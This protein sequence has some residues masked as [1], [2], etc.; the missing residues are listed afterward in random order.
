MI[1]LGNADPFH[2]WMPR[3]YLTPKQSDAP[4]ADDG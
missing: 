3:R 1:K 2:R 4:G